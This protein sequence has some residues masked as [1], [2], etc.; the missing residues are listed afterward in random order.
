MVAQHVHQ[1]RPGYAYIIQGE[2]TEYR[3]DNNE[4]L[5]R[6]AGDISYEATGI[7][8][9]WKNESTDPVEA[10]VVDIL[11]SEGDLPSTPERTP[12]R[13]GPTQSIGIQSVQILGETPLENEFVAFF[14]NN[15]GH[16]YLLW[17]QMR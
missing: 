17:T 6:R 13:K 11:P 4:P 14:R 15:Y 1:S 2:I 12:K 16:V 3:D 9:Y 10:L 8:H 7:T 5:L